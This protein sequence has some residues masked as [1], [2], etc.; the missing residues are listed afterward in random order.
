MS[1]GVLM[2]M[3][4]CVGCR[5]CQVSCK[6]AHDL[7]AE[8]TSFFAGQGYQNPPD[9]SGD[10]LTVVGFTEV[11]EEGKDLKWVFAK[12]QCMHCVEPS[13]V[14]A[15]LVGALIKQEDGSVTYDNSKCIGCR[16]CMIACPFQIPRLEWDKTVPF[17]KKCDNCFD[18]RNTD[19]PTAINGTA[20][21]GQALA[22]FATSQQT[23][24]CSKACPTQAIKF[25]ERDALL[26]EAWARINQN[27]GKYVRHVY[28]E[29]EAGGTSVLY[30]SSVSFDKIGFPMNVGTRAYPSYTHLA[31]SA[32]PPIIIGVGGLLAGV[33]W[34][35]QR[36]A[37]VQAAENTHGN[38]HQQGK[39]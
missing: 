17:I 16:Y 29:H 21:E 27:P 1:K 18:R 28:G 15:C 23:T 38:A 8:K 2:D 36:R 31:K 34:L 39:E 19:A 33:Y 7:P 24:A 20:L 6:Q 11:Q 26:A 13:C 12:K 5:G 30:I 4:K 32:I 35:N 3:T 22:T 37:E 9:L 10:T 14:S 25:G